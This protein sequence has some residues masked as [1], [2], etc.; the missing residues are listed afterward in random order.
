MVL[1][2]IGH[3]LHLGVEPSRNAMTYITSDVPGH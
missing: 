1:E 2:A 3:F